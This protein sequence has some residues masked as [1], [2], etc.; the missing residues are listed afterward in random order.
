MKIELYEH[1]K[2]YEAIKAWK[3]EMPPVQALPAVGAVCV[4]AKQTYQGGG[5]PIA[6]VW[7]VL[8]NSNGAAYLEHLSTD[9]DAG[10][11]RIRAAQLVVDFVEMHV[12][13]LGYTYLC[14]SARHPAIVKRAE[15]M[16]F[17]IV[18]ENVTNL[19]KII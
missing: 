8:S 3:I 16:G 18:G 19:A 12:K 6:C 7:A 4:H 10:K 11:L 2:H 13:E 1:D 5:T 17:S 14:M 15:A 9:P